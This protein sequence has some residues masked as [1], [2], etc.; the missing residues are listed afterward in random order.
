MKRTPRDTKPTATDVAARV[1]AMDDD[2]VATFAADTPDD[3]RK[4]A[5]S[6]LASADTPRARR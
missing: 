3:V 1:L 2:A 4:L 6:V 5:A